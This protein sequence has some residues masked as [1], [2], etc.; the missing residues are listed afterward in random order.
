MGPRYKL[1]IIMELKKGMF[2]RRKD[3]NNMEEH[4]PLTSTRV[5]FLDKNED[6]TYL[7]NGKYKVNVNDFNEISETD[8]TEEYSAKMNKQ[9]T[10]PKLKKKIVDQRKTDALKNLKFKNG[11]W[12]YKNN[13]ECFFTGLPA[14]QLKNIKIGVNKNG[15]P[16]HLLI[17]RSQFSLN[18]IPLT[19]IT[20]E[21]AMVMNEDFLKLKVSENLNDDFSSSCYKD[22]DGAPKKG[23]DNEKTILQLLWQ[24]MMRRP[25]HNYQAYQCGHCGKFHIGKA[26]PMN[27][28]AKEKMEFFAG[29][30]NK[31]KAALMNS[32][33]LRKTF[34]LLPEDLEDRYLGQ[35]KLVGKVGKYSVLIESR[36][37]SKDWVYLLE[38]TDAPDKSLGYDYVAP[39]MDEGDKSGT[40]TVNIAPKEIIDYIVNNVKDVKPINPKIIDATPLDTK[41]EK[42]LIEKIIDKMKNLLRWK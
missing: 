15:N 8:Y 4:H 18:R 39:W 31:E 17:G 33:I 41:G 11:D 25:E 26:L 29:F 13:Y 22:S 34:G 20:Q 7:V 32:E 36:C 38:V 27:D 40:R 3:G 37:F 10:L 21:E 35:Q 16:S 12:V 14:M 24:H 30:T 23:Y 1:R 9:P 2:I 19:K 28:R 6:G 42:T 5:K